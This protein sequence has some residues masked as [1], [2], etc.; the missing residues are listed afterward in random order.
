LKA[1]AI[2]NHDP[3][4]LKTVYKYDNLID[5]VNH[6]MYLKPDEKYIK[7]DGR[8][9]VYRLDQTRLPRLQG[10]FNSVFGAVFKVLQ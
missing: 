8:W 2:T 10:S 3:I 7:Y 9:R 1:K 4:F 6:E 5:L